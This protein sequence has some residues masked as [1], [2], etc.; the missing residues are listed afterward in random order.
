MKL[1]NVALVSSLAL[2][3]FAMAGCASK[4]DASE[5]TDS[6]ESQLVADSTETQSADDDVESGLEEPLSGAQ[7]SDPGT[8]AS[9]ADQDALVEKVKANVGKW[10]QPAGCI[11]TSWNANVATHVF[12]GC[13]GPY[14]FVSFN[15]TVTATYAYDGTTLTITYAATGFKAN[16]A[17][18]SGTRTVTYT[19]ATDGT[20]TKHRVGS[21]AGTTKNGKA[22][23]HEADFTVTWDPST[24]CITRDG[25]ADSTIAERDV[26]RTIA[27][28]KRCGLGDL[29]CPESGTIT[30]ERTKGDKSAS[31]TLELLGGQDYSITGPR[32]NTTSGQLVCI[33]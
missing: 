13:T 9:A 20:V 6:T 3:G 12:S 24:K 27:G 7:R 5:S 14:G 33:P 23:T 16:G 19:V 8:P 21:W 32:G 11:A 28:Y 30:L 26:S 29:G 1:S 18:I 25:T 4:N 15:G 31:V 17:Q 22:F 2:F 10:F